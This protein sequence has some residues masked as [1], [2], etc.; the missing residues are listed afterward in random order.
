MLLDEI[1]GAQVE[2]VFQQSHT[3][4]AR[5]EP[6]SEVRPKTSPEPRF[7][8][9]PEAALPVHTRVP[10]V[11][12]RPDPAPRTTLRPT[13]DDR[14]AKAHSITDEQAVLANAAIVNISGRQRMLCQRVAMYAA[15]LIFTYDPVER[16]RLCHNLKITIHQ[17]EQAH[18]ALIHG[19]SIGL[20]DT[21]QKNVAQHLPVQMSEAVRSLYFD[22]PLHLDQMVRM[23]IYATHQFLRQSETALTTDNSYLTSL[24]TMAEEDLLVG[25]EQLVQQYQRE[26]EATQQRWQTQQIHAAK[27]VALGQMVA[28]VAHEV[29]NPI[30]FVMGNLHFIQDY[31]EGLLQVVEAYQQHPPLPP[32][33]I[34]Q[35]LNEVDLEFIKTDLPQSL[36]SMQVGATRVRDIVQSLRNFSRLDEA[37][38]KTVDLHEGIDNTLV[39][40]RHALQGSPTLP[41]IA[42]VKD[43]GDLPAVECYA[44]MLNQVVMNL[45]ANAIDA[46]RQSPPPDMA[47]CIQIQTRPVAPHRV[48]IVITDNGPGI[49][50]AIQAKIFD[51]FFTTKPVGQGVGLGLA[52]SHQIVTEHH[53]GQLWCTAKLGRGTEFRLEIPTRQ[54]THRA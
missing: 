18:E 35:L 47:P 12:R 45:L 39:I 51:P 44:G 10:A 13:P 9:K 23:F 16:A 48:Q 4:V 11:A 31:T 43:Y 7:E 34:Q 26:E 17:M 28:G 25:L 2:T 50:A 8:T 42:L 6:R 14:L 53:G 29:N 24:L 33:T 38:L 37:D 19:G 15:R 27:M 21:G 40:L 3:V 22:A 46:L 54:S 30:N 5:P 36:S 52:I 32:A 20:G 1:D 49:P 41:S